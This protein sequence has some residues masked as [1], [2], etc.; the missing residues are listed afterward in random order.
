LVI[1]SVELE[2]VLVD[3]RLYFLLSAIYF[4]QLSASAFRPNYDVRAWEL[5]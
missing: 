5:C 2:R 3:Q 1:R 4:P